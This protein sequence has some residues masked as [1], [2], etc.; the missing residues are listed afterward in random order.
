[1]EDADG[2]ESGGVEDAVDD[3]GGGEGGPDDVRSVPVIPGI[4]RFAV[5]AAGGRPPGVPVADTVWG[6]RGPPL[7]RRARKACCSGEA[8]VT[9]M[10]SML[11]VVMACGRVYEGCEGDDKVS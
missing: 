7:A 10:K 1:M 2:E 5:A 11:P 4:G 9:G 8:S 6:R 3:V